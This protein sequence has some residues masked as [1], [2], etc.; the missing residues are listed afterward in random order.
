MAGRLFLAAAPT[1]GTTW[2]PANTTGTLSGG[3]LVVT[4]PVGGGTRAIRTISS[5]QKVYWEVLATVDVGSPSGRWYTGIVNSTFVIGSSMVNVNNAAFIRTGG[6]SGFNSVNASAPFGGQGDNFGI[7]V[8]F[9]HSNI[10]FRVN[11]GNWNNDILANQNP[12]TN[13][14]G[15]S[16]SGIGTPVWAAWSGL[17]NTDAVTAQFQTSS[18]TYTVPVGFTQI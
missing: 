4:A 11:G 18:W 9:V 10:W 13:T 16:F 1:A 6:L 5:G 3:N 15:I 14:G 7:A 12:A 8:D 17:D 2:D